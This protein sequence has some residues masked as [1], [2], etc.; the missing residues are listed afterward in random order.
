MR[1]G[2]FVDPAH[3]GGHTHGRFFGNGKLQRPMEGGD[4]DILQSLLN[5]SGIP[6]KPLHILH[7]LEVGHNYAPGVGQDVW[8]DKDS[9]V[10]QDAIG[11]QGRRTVRAFGENSAAQFC[12][13]AF[14]DLLRKRGGN[15]HAAIEL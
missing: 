12:G 11:L 2:D 4:Q 14:G 7:P 15:Q 1:L 10:L 8:D 9:L 13:I 5:V 6:E 3:Q